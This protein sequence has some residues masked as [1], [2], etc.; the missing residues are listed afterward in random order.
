[1]I[2]TPKRNV[3][4]LLSMIEPETFAQ[5]SKDPHW[6]KAMEEEMS[7]IEKNKTWEL[8]PRPKDNNIIGTKWV[9][10]NKM[11]EEGQVIINKARLVYKGYSQIEGIDFEETFAPVACMEAIRM[12]LAFSCSKGFKIYVKLAFLNGE[13]KEEVYVEEPEGFDLTEGKYLVWS[14]LD[15][16]MDEGKLLVTLVYVDD[17]IFASNN[18]EMSRGFSQN[19]SREF[20]MSTIGELSHFL[21]IQVSQPR[22]GLFISQAKYLKDMLKRYGMED[23][24]PMT[25]PMT[26]NSKLSKD[27]DST[28]ADATHYRSIIGALL[29]LTATRPNIMQVVGMVGR[30]QSTP[31]QSHLLV[32]KRILRYLKGT[33]NFD[34]WY[35]TSSTLTV[36]S[37]TNAN[38]AVGVND[39][40]STSGNAFFLGDYIVS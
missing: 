39:Q 19:M 27:D 33:P 37:Y 6:V 13:L 31:K 30:F 38:W 32:V 2:I 1:M 14:N 11:N 7:Q 34:L 22:A 18:D 25:T 4:A 10:K 3:I 5:A 23:C 26:T 9:L 16:K 29:Y 36:T 15:I 28:P 35:P 17:L 12:F 24:A 21:G 20:E 8:V 40:K